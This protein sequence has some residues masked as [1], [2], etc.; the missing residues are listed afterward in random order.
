M[1]PPGPNNPMG[2]YAL[3]LALKGYAIHGTNAPYGV[4]RRVSHGCIR[5]YPED[6]REL[7]A[8][9]RVG[10]PV[11]IVDQPAKAGWYDGTLYLEVH[12]RQADANAIEVHGRPLSPPD[13]A[14]D[15]VVRKAAGRAVDRVDWDSVLTA[16]IERSGMPVAVTSASAAAAGAQPVQAQAARGQAGIDPRQ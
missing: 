3:Y 9:V 13:T 16:E 5:L 14:A 11:T 4:G 8:R 1:V 12:P 6:I 2:D 15:A 10:T 7:Y